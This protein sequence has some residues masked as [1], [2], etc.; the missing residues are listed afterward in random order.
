MIPT[1]FPKPIMRGTPEGD[2]KER[3]MAAQGLRFNPGGGAAVAFTP[4]GQALLDARKRAN[5]ERD[6]KWGLNFSKAPNALPKPLPVQSGT[7]Q[8]QYPE[9]SPEQLAAAR[10]FYQR[11]A[12]TSP[13]DEQLLALNAEKRA[14]GYAE[15]QA[16][17]EKAGREHMARLGARQREQFADTPENA[18]RKAAY[19]KAGLVWGPAQK[20]VDQQRQIELDEQYGF[21]HVRRQSPFKRPLDVRGSN[22]ERV[23]AHNRAIDQKNR[24][25]WDI[26]ANPNLGKNRG[27]G[28]LSFAEEQ[29]K[30]GPTP[31]DHG[32]DE[33]K[34]EQERQNFFKQPH[35]AALRAKM[36]LK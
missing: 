29:A 23:A 32:Y 20:A 17:Q 3:E 4:Q 10:G 30:Y 19:Q 5:E 12:G 31:P 18:A 8:P 16:A 6:R 36:G 2:A 14:P 25:K 13:T 1:T 21:K 27:P 15:R 35:V 24:M 9:D 7:G 34:F 22:Y 26:W 11:V 28:A 33:A